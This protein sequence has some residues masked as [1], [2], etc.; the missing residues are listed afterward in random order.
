MSVAIL[1]SPIFS[2]R[3]SSSLC[4]SSASIT[5]SP[6]VLHGLPPTPSRS[7]SSSSSPLPPSPSTLSTVRFNKQ[8]STIKE[9]SCS[10]NGTVLKRKRPAR[11]DIPVMSLS[12]GVDTPKALE[13]VVDVVE[14]EGDEY[15]L[16]CKRGR[17]GLMED[18]YSAVVDVHGDSRQA[19]FGV[20]DGHGG[21]KAAQFAANHL[22]RHIMDQSRKRCA[23]EIVEAVR[24]G[25]LTTDAEFLK[26]G[27]EGG[28]CCVTALIQEGNLVVSN[29]GDCRAVMSRG[30][31]AEAL[32]SDHRPCREDEKQRIET[33]GGYVDSHHNVW[34]VQGSLAVSRG[35]GDR[36][37]KQ[38]IIAEP[39]TNVLKIEH[40]CEFVI[41]ASDGLWDKVNNQEA[42]DMVRP[43]CTGI[44]K[45]KPFFACKKLVDLAVKR[46]ST[47][48][49][50]VMIVQLGNFLS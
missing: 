35:I 45:P 26:Q 17:R 38:W 8:I 4:K 16:Y 6:R 18:R 39:E 42:A 11:I 15:A 46:G 32:T 33:L 14:V 44:E 31:I 50:S 9:V 40:D 27:V 21:A 20:F 43:L 47:D 36:H 30:G 19:F 28:T 41:L 24:D 2:P 5:K 48:D 12:F 29:A 37:L 49:I 3:V 1:N 34:R 23:D 25:Y 22:D 13:R 10:L 7:S